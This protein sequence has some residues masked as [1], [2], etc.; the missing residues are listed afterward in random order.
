M[1]KITLNYNERAWAIEV[2]SQIN[3]ICSKYNFSIKKAGGENTLKTEEKNLFPDLLLFGDESSGIVLQGWELKMPDTPIT[4]T[5][6]INNA[7][8][9]AEKMGLN[10]F[11]LWNAREAVL[12]AQKDEGFVAIENWCVAGIEIREDVKRLE[13]EWKNTLI[14]IISYLSNFFTNTQ[15]RSVN[16]VEFSSNLYVD[17]LRTYKNI[18]IANISKKFTTNYNLEIEAEGWIRENFSES[19]YKNRKKE[20]MAEYIILSWLNR[21]IFSHYLKTFNSSAKVIENISLNSQFEEVVA[22]FDEIT[23]QCDFM[24]VFALRFGD[25]YIDDIFLSYLLQINELLKNFNFNVI[26][27]QYLHSVIDNALTSSRKKIAGLFST[28]QNLANYLVGITLD[29]REGHIIDPCCG[30]GTIAKAIYMEKK[31]KQIPSHEAMK[32][33]W[34]SDKFI[35]PLQLC[36]IAL[37]DSEAKGSLVRVF[38]SDVF[39]LEGG[40]KYSFIDPYLNKKITKELPMM[41]AIV[42]NLP[43]ISF[44]SREEITKKIACIEG[45]ENL[46]LSKRSDLYAYIIFY[47]K[48]LVEDR[49][50]IGVVT[51]NSWLGVEWGEEF[52]K[53]LSEH[54]NILSVVCSGSG[55]WFKNAKVVTTILILQKR[56]KKND[57]GK[58]ISFVTTELPIEKWDRETLDE[59]I[60]ATRGKIFS[61]Y[62]S[63]K[64]YS[65]EKIRQY[66]QMGV[67]WNALFSDLGWIEKIQ[68]KIDIANKHLSFS[69]GE[70]RGWDEMF[71]PNGEHNIEQEYLKPALLTPK[72]ISKKLIVELNDVAFCCSDS[73]E[74][75]QEK[76]HC[77][78][79][80]WIEKFRYATNT[81]NKP[82]PLVL[83]RKNLEW[84]EMKS[85]VK[86]DMVI[87]INPDERIC[88]YRLKEEGLVNQRFMLLKAKESK[89]TELLHALLNSVIGIFYIESNGFGRGDGVL[90]LNLEV[91]SKKIH[92]LNPNLINDSEKKR[93]LESFQPLLKREVEKLMDELAMEDRREFDQTV[94]DVF[95]IRVELDEIYKSLKRIFKIRRT[96]KDKSF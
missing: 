24:N 31:K 75:L 19:E 83:A 70:R 94:L 88:V 55:R 10:S 73:I 8:M 53:Y 74:M 93:I 96:V 33:V 64:I 1:G 44:G 13:N 32:Q 81:K 91:F 86:A 25:T 27:S 39:E 12:Y 77:G 15:Y 72:K 87:P 45:Y 16:L 4:D 40:K 92:I 41:H 95:D 68:N 2:I 80:Q 57:I 69:R 34:A 36:S 7:R 63:K 46:S 49:G 18:L 67:A 84:Y 58:E 60:I 29:N 43:F 89:N 35:Y 56:G 37:S 28:P 66:E 21:F 30:T 14:E 23:K 79:I 3:I 51:S 50:K 62:I 90:D 76:N 5:E 78:A 61:S 85:E 82:L 48:T 52:K 47:L 65:I 20:I 26:E 9:K 17:A 59:M 6:F 22:I 71:Y 38:R 42:S 11:V 54:F